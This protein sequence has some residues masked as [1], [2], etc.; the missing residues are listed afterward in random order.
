MKKTILLLSTIFAFN[1][2]YAQSIIYHDFVPDTCTV[3]DTRI[4]VT[5]PLFLDIN[6]DGE[7]EIR[8]TSEYD[9]HAIGTTPKLE[10]CRTGWEV[11]SLLRRNPAGDCYFQ[12]TI[13]TMPTWPNMFWWNYVAAW[14]CYN[15]SRMGVRYKSG[16]DYYYGWLSV[17]QTHEVISIPNDLYIESYW[18][19]A[20]AFCTIPNYPLVWGQTK[21]TGIDDFEVNNS[22]EHPSL[23]LLY[24]PVTNIL[25]AIASEGNINRIEIYNT[26]GKLVSLS[27]N[28][29]SNHLEINVAMLTTG[30]YV[31]KSVLDNKSVI[32]NKFI[33]IK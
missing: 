25:D 7:A 9:P 6:E 15:T 33:K 21:I 30:V 20:M 17:Y 3:M 19:D 8:I 31:V 13:S 32:T 24:N 27:H 18:V 5:I 11:C 28:N 4:Q 26:S 22:T 10:A 23:T 14:P 2:I 16:E 1:C 29:N 12:D